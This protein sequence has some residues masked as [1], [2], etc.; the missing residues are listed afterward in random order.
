MEHSHLV[1][2]NGN[3]VTEQR[4]F[5]FFEINQFTKKVVG[6][7]GELINFTKKFLGMFEIN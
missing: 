7:F 1:M 5:V 3:L 6:C 2:E 4:F